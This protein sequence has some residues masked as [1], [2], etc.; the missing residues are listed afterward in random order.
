MTEKK[1]TVAGEVGNLRI[2]SR[3][4]AG[5]TS[6]NIDSDGEMP[7]PYLI[8]NHRLWFEFDRIQL[9]LHYIQSYMHKNKNTLL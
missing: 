4:N 8:F 6:C 2:S 3:V 5:V 7:K 9:K 1:K